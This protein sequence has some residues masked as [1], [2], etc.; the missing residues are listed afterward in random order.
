MGLDGGD[1]L[2][3]LGQVPAGLVIGPGDRGM[4]EGRVGAPS[5]LEHELVHAGQLPKHPVEPMDDL[6]RAL[7]GFDVLIGMGP[8]HERLP[9]ERLGDPRVVFHGA[10]TEQA[11][12]HHPQHLLAEM[13]VV[14]QHL[15]LREL[16]QIDRAAPAQGFGNQV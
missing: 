3:P 4:E 11:D 8:G 13:Q 6:E 9:G 2:A 5:G 15:G 12:A 16:G 14:A 1:D 7:E 10:G